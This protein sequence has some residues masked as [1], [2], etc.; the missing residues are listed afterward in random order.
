MNRTKCIVF[1]SFAMAAVPAEAQ[2]YRV[3]SG[4][5]GRDIMNRPLQGLGMMG[6][7]PPGVGMMG[8]PGI[9]SQPPFGGFPNGGSLIG[10]PGVGPLPGQGMPGGGM[11]GMGIVG[12]PRFGPQPPFGGFQG[13]GLPNGGMGFGGGI[14]GGRQGPT[15]QPPNLGPQGPIPGLGGRDKDDDGKPWGSYVPHIIHPHI[16]SFHPEESI[17]GDARGLGG[18]AETHPTFRAPSGLSGAGK[19]FGGLLAGIGAAV[20]GVFR[21]IFGSGRVD[22]TQ[23]FSDQGRS[24]PLGING[25]GGVWI[26]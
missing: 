14:I 10:G 22:K 23:G 15:Q 18:L 9:G 16:P 19:W 1:L 8:G 4:K 17:A 11:S 3:Q 13:N 21:S 24:R 2:I 26:R 6:G 20:A 5:P 7:L 12:G 25:K